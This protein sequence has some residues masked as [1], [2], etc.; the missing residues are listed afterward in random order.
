M[1]IE[2]KEL[3]SNGQAKMSNGE[4]WQ[5]KKWDGPNYDYRTPID[6]HDNRDGFIHDLYPPK[7]TKLRG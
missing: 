1:K 6:Y 3:L 7:N 4:I 5:R 2:I